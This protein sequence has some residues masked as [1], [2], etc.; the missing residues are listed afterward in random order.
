MPHHLITFAPQPELAHG[1]PPAVAAPARPSAVGVA[2]ACWGVGGQLVLL[3]VPSRQL[4]HAAVESLRAPGV[5]SWTWPLA[6]ASIVAMCF[7]QGYLGFQRRYAPLVAARAAHLARHPR[8]W[9][10]ALAPLYVC[11]LLH[12]SP[13]RRL[14]TTLIFAIMPA[15]ALGVSRLPDPF[16]GVVDL[17]VACGLL[18]GTV[19]VVVSS[20]RAAAGRAPA[21]SLELP[22][23]PRR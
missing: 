12:A 4:A 6:A 18:W 7:F 5:A 14:T 20:V 23:G 21:V 19:T 22:A 11:G 9:H 16:R 17:G 1:A 2:A 13:R 3:F 8:P 10:A 15:L